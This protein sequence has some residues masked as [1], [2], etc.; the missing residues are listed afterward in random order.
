MAALPWWQRLPQR[1]L[2]EDAQL[3]QL[4]AE[5]KLA[6]YSW[7]RRDDGQLWLNAEII[8]P[9]E[10]SQWVELRFPE[11]YPGECPPM[12]PLPY[13]TSLSGHQ[14]GG[15]GV[16][17]LELGPDNWHSR[18]MAADLLTSAW[19][20]L[21]YEL[22][23][24]IK[25]LRIPSRDMDTLGMGVRGHMF[26]VVASQAARDALDASDSVAKFRYT[27]ALEQ[28]AFLM[29]LAEAPEGS[30]VP[31]LPPPI[32][33]REKQTG[34]AIRISDDAP[35]PPDDAVELR[36]YMKTMGVSEETADSAAGLVL[37][38]RP[39]GTHAK[40]LLTATEV[41]QKVIVIPDRRVEAPER[42][43]AAVA[44]ATTTAR[45]AIIG[46]GSLGS[47]VATSLARAGVTNFVFVDGDVFLP[48]NVGRHDSDL[49]SA[50][51]MKT[52][53]A[54]LRV[55]RVATATVTI[56]SF[57]H[58]VVDGSNPAIHA[59][60]VAA[61]ASA[62]LLIDATANPE[63]FNFLADLASEERRRFAW[64]EIF[65]GGLGGYIAY[66]T[67]ER[68]PCPSCVRAA[69]DGYAEEWPPAPPRGLERYGAEH[70]GGGPP[71]LASDA[72]VG[73]IAA[74]LSALSLRLLSGVID[75]HA[76]LLVIGLRR[77]WI[78]DH[79]FDARSL[80]VRKDDFG[81]E[82][83]WNRPAAP[84][85]DLQKQVEAILSP[86]HVDDPSST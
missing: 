52:D 12:R 15:E 47:K 40:F 69:F 53:A 27:L 78:F 77:E 63:A 57:N 43:P 3:Q 13:G 58:D 82:R 83:C 7:I 26:R 11:R 59:E 17:C 14:Y 71:L 25:P 39:S 55:K 66:A 46:L 37:F 6:K 60:T 44:A 22:L 84:D 76:P 48:E 20:L 30:V 35:T 21:V 33:A 80:P 54:A 79:A 81:C 49:L 45:V 51:L 5:R 4:V 23:N 41:T 75:D 65:G 64:G 16:L 72:D 36:A 38:L 29:W 24:K 28:N 1:V 42:R 9:T 56:S 31:E 32:A 8:I 74:A 50:G 67:P 10:N 18:F 34:L 2:D 85:R 73:V 62:D 86:T 70:P 68:T 19:K 61:L